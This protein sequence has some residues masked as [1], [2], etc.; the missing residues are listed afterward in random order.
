MVS[1]SPFTS[2]EPL[3]L[4]F[5]PWPTPQNSASDIVMDMLG[6]MLENDSSKLETLIV[7]NVN[8]IND[9]VGL[10]F[11]TPSS[12]Y[13][14]H[15]AMNG[16]II[17]QHPNQTLLDIACG[18]PCGPTIWILLSH[19]ATGSRHPYGTDLA[20]HNA[21]KNGRP[22]TVQALL[23][24]GRSDV[25][26]F[27]GTA[28]KPLLQGVFWNY[29][30]V[31]R[32][33][34]RKGANLEDVGPS[35]TAQGYHTALQIC[36]DRRITNYEDPT[37]RDRSNLT[38]KMLLDAGANI[39]VEP[40]QSSTLTPF[41][42]FVK[43]WENQSYWYMK[44]SVLELE[45]L[46]M[47]VSRGANLQVSFSG[48]PCG[49]KW[50]QNFEHQ[51]LWHSTPTIARLV[52]DSYSMTLH[53]NGSSLLHELLGSCTEAKRYPT[54][55]LR[56]MQVLLQQGV[57]PNGIDANGIS[58]LRRCMEQCLPANLVPRLQTLLDAGADPEFEDH[59]GVQPYVLAAR[60]FAE[61]LLSQVMQNLVAHFRGHQKKIIDGVSHT[62]SSAHF[63]IAEDQTYQQVMSC[64][65]SDGAFRREVPIMVPGDIHEVFNRA[66]LAV[67]SEKFLDT[68]TRT[69]K[70][71]LL[72]ARDKNETVW[73]V[74]MRKRIGLPD[75]QFSQDF[76]IDLLD[77]QPLLR[78]DIEPSVEVVTSNGFD[79][80]VP[81]ELNSPSAPTVTD[82][83]SAPT[84]PVRNPWQFNP[85][86]V[87]TSPDRPG[88]LPTPPSPISTND[89][90]LMIPQATHI[91][92][93]YP[94][95]KTKPGDLEKAIAAA[96]SY[97]CRV[98]NDG[99]LLTKKSEERHEE[100]HA[101]TSACEGAD[102]MRRFCVVRRK[103]EHNI[104]CQD[105]LF[106]AGL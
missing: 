60:T 86:N 33:L 81:D 14:G 88:T 4:A 92:W 24:P 63:P 75:Y 59:N 23:V 103:R 10:P 57:D 69:A 31:V 61:P 6:A 54:D 2:L 12:R 8:H 25:Q 67:V 58:P 32:I 96:L 38:L 20:L 9:P 43:P 28:W 87:A 53:N 50:R 45:C 13:F 7:E 102:C 41:A 105:H 73:V 15:P 89:D 11:N 21:I 36:L 19:G 42:A 93:K 65:H 77:P 74:G 100:E 52:V 27:P 85:N 66:Y 40:G 98:C 56:D 90:D 22:Y 39:H 37:N 51:V 101:H 97:K 99:I 30:E 46:R 106:A 16:M 29:P 35:P 47:F 95:T 94:T 71:R 48:C 82:A 5:D 64:S 26:G 62:W 70:S 3:T 34:L 44:L 76:V 80:A 72:T 83:P 91:R 55:T 68:M 18:M 1:C 49:A 78:M 79:Q 84:S 17:M 104:V